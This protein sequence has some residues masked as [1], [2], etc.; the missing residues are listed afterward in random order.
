MKNS[1]DHPKSVYHGQSRAR[2][3]L[4]CLVK[5]SLDRYVVTRPITENHCYTISGQLAV[6][7]S[8][9]N[10]AILFGYNYGM[11]VINGNV[12]NSARCFHQT[13]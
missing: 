5:L 11:L 1:A 8:N 9:Y 10:S 6:H 13:S 3:K 4:L 12:V 7:S 2:G